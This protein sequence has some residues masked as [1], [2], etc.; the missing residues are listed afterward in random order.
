MNRE[1]IYK[2]VKNTILFYSPPELYHRLRKLLKHFRKIE[3]YGSNAGLLLFVKAET[4]SIADSNVRVIRDPFTVIIIH[5]DYAEIYT[6][7]IR[8]FKEYLDKQGLKTLSYEIYKLILDEEREM[9]A[10]LL[11]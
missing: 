3:I 1:E 10:R 5:E 11:V 2:K 7:S 8:R 6:E 4:P 9:L